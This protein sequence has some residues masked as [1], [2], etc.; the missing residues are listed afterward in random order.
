MPAEVIS[1]ARYYVSAMLDAHECWLEAHPE[2]KA[3]AARYW[4]EHDEKIVPGLRGNSSMASTCVAHGRVSPTTLATEARRRSMRRGF[5]P[6]L[7]RT[8]QLWPGWRG[9]LGSQ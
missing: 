7:R 5:E 4:I 1:L 6:G 9:Q 2:K 8:E 3:E